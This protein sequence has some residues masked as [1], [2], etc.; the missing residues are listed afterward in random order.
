MREEVPAFAG[1]DPASRTSGYGTTLTAVAIGLGIMVSPDTVAAVG[2]LAGQAGAWFPLLMFAGV[3]VHWT[4]AGTY[5][6]VSQ[7]GTGVLAETRLVGGVAAPLSLLGRVVAAV[8]LSTGLLV[9]AGFAFNEV[10]LYWFPNFAF[11]FLLLGVI[12]AVNL[13]GRSVAGI[14]QT[15]FS[16]VAVAGL[17]T[18]MAAWAVGSVRS[19]PMPPGVPATVPISGLSLVLMMFVGYDMAFLNAAHSPGP[20]TGSGSVGRLLGIVL[21]SALLILTLWGG[22]STTVVSAG[23]LADSSIPHILAA[24]AISGDTGRVIMGTVIIAGAAAAVNALFMTV[25]RMATDLARTRPHPGI[26]G[27]RVSSGVVLAGA[28]AVLMAGGAAGSDTLETHI[29]GAFV[30]WLACTAAVSA[31]FLR[32]GSQSRFRTAVN[33]GGI[34]ITAG[35]MAMLVWT[36]PRPGLLLKTLLIEAGVAAFIG[37]VWG[38]RRKAVPTRKPKGE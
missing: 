7:T 28:T 11:A 30:L 33:A 17:V 14:A 27:R 15:L 26:W 8:V 22:I 23:R 36:D 38:R 34:L 20:K 5:S 6:A 35:C 32:H 2:R 37:A 3:L 10:F 1:I 21:I 12:L 24:R 18:L 31:A 19:S 13:L 16:G 4:H 29:R 9:S 25:I